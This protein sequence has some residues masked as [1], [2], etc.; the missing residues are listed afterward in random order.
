MFVN[1]ILSRKHE[2]EFY[3]IC[4]DEHSVLFIREGRSRFRSQ[5]SVVLQVCMYLNI[6]QSREGER[7]KYEASQM[8]YFMF[9]VAAG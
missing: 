5:Q 2:C 6:P 4:L 3:W 8:L 7:E 9:N 1:P